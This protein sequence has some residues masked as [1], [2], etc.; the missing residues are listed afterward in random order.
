MTHDQ[1][2]GRGEASAAP[3][4]PDDLRTTV[5]RLRAAVAADC[6]PIDRIVNAVRRASGSIC[7]RFEPIG[8]ETIAGIANRRSWSELTVEFSLRAL[9]RPFYNCGKSG[10]APRLGR[11]PLVIGFIMPGNVAGA[12]LHE[13]VAASLSNAAILI[14]T[15]FAE[16]LFF[17]NFMR[18][19]EQIDPQLGARAA[20]LNWARSR[21]DLSAAMLTLCDRVVV[22]GD[23]GTLANV[24][25]EWDGLTHRGGGRDFAG[26]GARVSGAVVSAGALGKSAPRNLAKDVVSFEQR[27]CLSPHHVF[28]EDPSDSEAREFGARLAAELKAM[29][30]RLPP[31]V[32]LAREDAAAIRSAREG[33]RWRALG[34]EAVQ[35]WEGA[36]LDWTV[37]YDRDAGFTVSPGYRTVYVSPFWDLPD[38]GRRLAP[39]KG[40]LEACALAAPEHRSLPLRSVLQHAGATYICEPGQMQSPPLDWPHGSGAFLRMLTGEI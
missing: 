31:P 30:R 38:L 20:V 33:A 14:K 24:R 39:L 23:D 2:G 40:R 27:G 9:C 17:A 35:L 21:T 12:G 22:F 26:F 10:F 29:A 28:I 5:A 36:N 15:A 11:R 16:P 34:G 6:V 13:V 4:V 1:L 25:T 19:L 8:R 18:L 7:S 32:G 37:I 3:L